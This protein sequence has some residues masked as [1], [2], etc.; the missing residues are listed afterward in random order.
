MNSSFG[1]WSTAFD[2]G[3]QHQLSTFWKRR[4]ALLPALGDSPQRVARRSA[5]LLGSLALLVLGL[6]TF[7]RADRSQLAASGGL[8]AA[9]AGDARGR[10]TAAPH[11]QSG[12]AVAAA[13]QADAEELVVYLPRPSRAETK[14]LAALARPMDVDFADTP[15]EDCL[16][17]IKDSL[18]VPEFNLF[19]DKP[20]LADEGVALDQPITLKMKS[21]RV[22]SVLKMLLRPSQLDF[23]VEDDVL[24][25]MTAAK[26]GERLVTRIYPLS[27]L[28]PR[29]PMAGAPPAAQAARP[30]LPSF[31]DVKGAITTTIEP[32][33]W[34]AQAGPGSCV[35]MNETRSLVIRQTWSV[36]RQ[37]VHL[38][39]ELREA[40]RLASE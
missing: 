18:D 4:L 40:E 6:P 38:L 31:D 29:R 10:K 22:E 26:A 21:V 19:I 16:A 13:N 24:K 27:D 30:H 36:H 7:E 34:E 23:F 32:E 37:I 2:S 14:I 8:G 17:F 25:I 1:P 12:N 11:D 33:T 15:L 20:N 5:V 39:G 35:A 28:Y 3:A 9:V